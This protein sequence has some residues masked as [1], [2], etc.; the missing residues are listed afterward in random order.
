MKLPTP[1]MWPDHQAA[2]FQFWGAFFVGW[3]K[4]IG[5]K[6]WKH[7]FCWVFCWVF[8]IQCGWNDFEITVL[9]VRFL[10]SLGGNWR[11]WCWHGGTPMA[12]YHATIDQCRLFPQTHSCKPL[13]ISH[14]ILRTKLST[15]T[16]RCRSKNKQRTWMNIM[17]MLIRA[18]SESPRAVGSG[19]IWSISVKGAFCSHR[20]KGQ[21]QAKM[22]VEELG[23]EM[24]PTSFGVRCSVKCII[25]TVYR[26]L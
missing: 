20:W 22:G 2:K 19:N 9:V 1:V 18:V 15:C 8:R 4:L 12:H 26:C 10:W 6:W 23:F 21:L 16:S 5:G 17:F 24:R 13:V 25:F 7:L 3:L 11:C 14:G